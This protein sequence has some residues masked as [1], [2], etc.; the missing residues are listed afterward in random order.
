MLEFKTSEPLTIG[1]ELEIQIINKKTRDLVPLAGDV[2]HYLETN[3]FSDQI[4]PEITQSMLEINSSVHSSPQ[5]LFKEMQAIRNELIK[6]TK[7]LDIYFSGGGTH[8][9]QMWTDRKIYP[10]PRYEK[11]A[12]KYGYLAKMFTVF[13]LHIHIGCPNGKEAIYLSHALARYMPQFIALSA[14]S[15]FCQGID[16][17]FYSSRSNVVGSFPLSGLLP[18]THASNW[19]DFCCYIKKMQD[20]KIIEKIDNFYWDIR[21]RPEYGTVEIRICDAPLTIEKATMLAAYAQTLAK[22]ILD[23][24]PFELTHTNDHLYR[25]NR[26]QASRFGF[27]G[28]YVNPYTHETK[29]VAEDIIETCEHLHNYSAKLDNKEFLLK[30]IAMALAKENDAQWLKNLYADGK[31]LEEIVYLQS[32]LWSGNLTDSSQQSMLVA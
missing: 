28:T 31:S 14:S 8:P 2:I 17:N 21:P 29:A 5:N 13:G 23:K 7:S 26:F 30:I 4:K 1:V 9:F 18:Y 3:K 27:D 24:K 12:H 19:S 15:P 11:T 20:L 6:Q 16:T 10:V 22:Y 32:N 25:Y